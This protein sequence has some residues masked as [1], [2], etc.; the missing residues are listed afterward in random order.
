MPIQID[1][2]KAHDLAPRWDEA[3][4]RVR[5]EFEGL[6]PHRQYRNA[7]ARLLKPDPLGRVPMMGTDQR[8]LFV[9]ALRRVI[10]ACVP[11]NGHI[12]D[13][14]REMATRYLRKGHEFPYAKR[15][16]T[17][18]VVFQSKCIIY[19]YFFGSVRKMSECFTQ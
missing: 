8:D 15:T 2:S 5:N 9:P 13:F 11:T 14:G 18:N 3:L 4:E 16:L 19:L 1:R 7:F 6:D 12:L 10:E 17:S